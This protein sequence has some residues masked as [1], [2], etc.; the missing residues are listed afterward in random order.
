MKPAA[1]PGLTPKFFGGAI[2]LGVII[3]Q[4]YQTLS[5]SQLITT[6][7]DSG[8]NPEPQRRRGQKMRG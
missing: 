5:A 4:Y 6:T 8:P 2:R 1:L 3:Y 7:D